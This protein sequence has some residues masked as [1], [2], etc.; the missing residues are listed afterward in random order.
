MLA[1]WVHLA[2]GFAALGAFALLLLAGRARKPSAQAW[3][4]RCLQVGGAGTVLALVSGLVVLGVQTAVLEERLMAALEPAALGRVLGATRFGTLW[5]VRQGLLTLLASLLLLRRPDPDGVAAVPLRAQGLLLASAAL[6]TLA[7]AGHAAAVEPSTR[8]SELLDAV[9]L[10]AAGVWVGGLWPLARLC[11]LAGR[12]PG[13]DAR[14]FAVLAAHRFSTMALVA[15]LVL[16]TTGLWSAWNQVGTIPAL[17]G[18]LYGRLL[19]VKLSLLAPIAVLAVL[20]RR[21]L[22]PALGGAAETVG[23]PAMRRLAI[24]VGA[25]ALIALAIL[26]VVAS[27]TATPPGR[28]LQPTWP[29]DFRLSYAA[30]ADRPRAQLRVLVGSQLALVGVIGAIATAIISGPSRRPRPPGISG[31]SR[32]PGTAGISGPS[33]SPR[34]SGARTHRLAF[35]GAAATTA[36]GLLVALPPLT[37]AAYPTTYRRPTVP[38]QAGSITAGAK[39]YAVHCTGCHAGDAGDLTTERVARHTAGDVF[40]WLSRGIPGTA[41]PGFAATLAEEPRWDLVN[42]LRAR[43]AARSAEALGPIVEPERP[44]LIAPDF[45]YAVGPTPA[46]TLRELR[47]RRIALLVLFTLPGSRPRLAQLAQAYQTLSAIGVEVIAAP[48]T[49][50]PQIIR[51]VGADPPVFFPLVTEGAAEI[52]QTYRLFAPNGGRPDHV[53]LLIDRQGYIRARVV[54]PAGPPPEITELLAE[55]QQLNQEPQGVPPPPD[56]IH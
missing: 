22:L 28:H 30:V 12:D 41:M 16:L 14:P 15:I 52:A 1:R 8:A 55:I 25:E 32:R 56:H 39:L 26:A 50:D 48:T 23:R 9:H 53:E 46:H 44:W 34:S 37:M 49:P 42:F 4:R 20:N 6:A 19:L 3:E 10:V 54:L 36:V 27:M 21:R 2:G 18:T 33:R 47:D 5:L 24:F 29:F 38:Y 17:V 7:F 13:A 11:R 31:P 35:A 40:W 43:A 51:R 45:A